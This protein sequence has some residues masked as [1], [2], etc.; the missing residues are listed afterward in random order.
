[1]TKVSP[2]QVNKTDIKE[3]TEGSFVSEAIAQLNLPN[4]KRTQ[5][6]LT[7]PKGDGTEV[8]AGG[9]L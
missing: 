3:W 8:I 6:Y 1:M 5:K 9:E 2:P 7:F 4:L